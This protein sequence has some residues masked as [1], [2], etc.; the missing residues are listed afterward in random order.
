M[1]AR[2]ADWLGAWEAP[3]VALEQ[4]GHSLLK[5]VGLVPRDQVGH[6]RKLQQGA[7]SYA[8]V[9]D[10][11]MDVRTSGGRRGDLVALQETQT[12]GR[13]AS[14]RHL[15]KHQVDQKIAEE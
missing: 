14:P 11:L 12:P 2:E 1:L 8:P 13:Q 9:R 3:G 10:T 15:E 5:K 7:H 6:I 4:I